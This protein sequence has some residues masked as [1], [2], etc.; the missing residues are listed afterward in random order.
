[1]IV[2]HRTS[3]GGNPSS[4]DQKKSSRNAPN[5][6]WKVSKFPVNFHHI[7]TGNSSNFLW[8]FFHSYPRPAAWQ[9]ILLVVTWLGVAF[10]SLETHC[11]TPQKNPS[12]KFIL[13]PVPSTSTL[14]QN[15]QASRCSSLPPAFPFLPSVLVK[16]FPLQSVQMKSKFLFYLLS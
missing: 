4:T 15:N 11:T 10:P 8:I 6:H 13:I 5:F 12:F 1:M 7:S 16:S 3:L 2:G 9:G 14:R